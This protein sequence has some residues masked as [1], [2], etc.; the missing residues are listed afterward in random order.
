MMTVQQVAER[1]NLSRA[2]V[3]ALCACGRLAHHRL[4]VGQGAI[5]IS[6]E[7]LERFLKETECAPPPP[8]RPGR[9]PRRITLKHLELGPG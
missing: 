1:L 2:Q 8:A 7:Q 4:G 9:P 5:R 6:E 3:Y